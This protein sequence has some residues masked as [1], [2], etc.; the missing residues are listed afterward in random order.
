V[1]GTE[2][3]QVGGGLESKTRMEWWGWLA[4]VVVVAAGG[5]LGMG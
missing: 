5:G 3:E 4:G 1:R 2:E